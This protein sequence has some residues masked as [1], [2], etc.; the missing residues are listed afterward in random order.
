MPSNPPEVGQL[1]KLWQLDL[2]S[3]SLTELPAELGQLTNLHELDLRENPLPDDFPTKLKAI[4]EYLQ[5]QQNE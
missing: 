3:N 2:H 4:M 1:T 5:E